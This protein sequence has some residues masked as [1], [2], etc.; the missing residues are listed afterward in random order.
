MSGRPFLHQEAAIGGQ[1][2]TKCGMVPGAAPSS[3]LCMPAA[4]AGKACPD[5]VHCPGTKDHI[6]D[7]NDFQ[8][9]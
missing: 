4:F 6:T 5:S 2:S 8:N 3:R 7:L 9:L 1:M